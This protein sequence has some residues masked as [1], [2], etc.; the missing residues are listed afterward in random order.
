MRKITEES[1]KKNVLSHKV[2]TF[3][4]YKTSYSDGC[5]IPKMSWLSQNKVTSRRKKRINIYILHYHRIT[6][7]LS[8]KRCYSF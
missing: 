2:R 4:F 5:L 7:S 3:D 8:W 6:E 1:K